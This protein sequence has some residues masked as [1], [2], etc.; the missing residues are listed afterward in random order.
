VTLLRGASGRGRAQRLDAGP[1]H[2]REP[3]ESLG[4]K[5]SQACDA[6]H[7]YDAVGQQHSAGEGV[8]ASTGMTHKGELVDMQRVRDIRDELGRRG[9]APAWIGRRAAVSGPVVRHPPEAEPVCSE[10]Q[11]LGRR[12]DVR[13]AVVPEDCEAVPLIPVSVIDMERAAVGKLQIELVHRPPHLATPSAP[14]SFACVPNCGKSLLISNQRASEPTKMCSV[15]RILGAVHELG[16]KA[17]LVLR[18]PPRPALKDPEA[19]LVVI[20]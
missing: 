6:D 12:A 13:R 17:D 16:C 1:R 5:R 7:G 11:G 15:G 8:G 14:S 10:E 19:R 4:T 9:E 2:A 3:V 18:E 20:R